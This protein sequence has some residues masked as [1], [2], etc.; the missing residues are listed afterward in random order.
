VALETTARRLWQVFPLTAS[1][2][3]IEELLQR[4]LICFGFYLI[5]VLFEEA[6]SKTMCGYFLVGGAYRPHGQQLLI[7]RNPCGQISSEV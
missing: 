6:F 1:S 5:N 4:P 3:G 7:Q 2:V